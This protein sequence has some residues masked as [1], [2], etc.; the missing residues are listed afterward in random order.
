MTYNEHLLNKLVSDYPIT[1]YP[2][3]MKSYI[4]LEKTIKEIN[5]QIESL[6]KILNFVKVN[7]TNSIKSDLFC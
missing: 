1:K 7:S 3:T 6:R 5:F 4:E 2:E